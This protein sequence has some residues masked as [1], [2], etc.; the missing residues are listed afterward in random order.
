MAKP[1]NKKKP[2][3][4]RGKRK[5]ATAARP[6][7]ALKLAAM[8]SYD[9]LIR[10]PCG[11]AFAYP[12]YAGTETGYLVRLTMSLQPTALG[13][14]L[15]V[16]NAYS[17]FYGIQLQPSTFP[18]YVQASSTTGSGANTW[19]A[20]TATANNFLASSAVK[21]YRPVAACL[22]WVP[23][24]AIAT[25]AGM[26]G[27]GYTTA[28]VAAIGATYDGSAFLNA[29]LERASNGSSE[30]EV[31]WLPNP[32]DETFST[33]GASQQ[34]ISGGT[35]TICLHGVD[36]V[37]TSTTGVNL[38]G[39]LEYTCVYEWIPSV[40]NQLT[41]AP[42]MPPPFT[43]QEYQSTIGDVGEFLLRGVRTVSANIV[44]AGVTAAVQSISSLTSRRRYTPGMPMAV[45][46]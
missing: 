25:R 14:G 38:N 33:S 19:G 10:D 12:P 46:Y 6:T 18:M 3:K 40:V 37:A 39:L 16:G 27:V 8:R 45:Q 42:K 43:S 32:S 13:S 24:S 22:K 31:R 17:S 35:V 36:G 28:P 20:L 7:N 34:Y 4:S 44:G 11:A 9:M 15:T 2:N 5:P 30:H 29:Q 21:A 41:V 1:N 23:T 26:V